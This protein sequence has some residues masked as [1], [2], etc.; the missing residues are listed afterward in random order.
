MPDLGLTTHAHRDFKF[1]ELE[2]GYKRT[3]STPYRVRFE[4]PSVFVELLF[5]GDRSFELGLLVGENCSPSC[6]YSIDEILWLRRAPDASTF[7]LIQ[8]TTRAAMGAWLRK[9]AKA[10]RSYG[11]DLIAGNKTSFSELAN[12]RHAYVRTYALESRLA[13]A[14]AE[15]GLAW[16]KKDYASVVKA[17]KPVRAA[18][19]AAEVGKLEFAESHCSE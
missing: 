15:A 5:D 7:S 17:L 12:Q 1:L 16:R 2:M 14:R 6:A 9:L 3:E 8:V 10:L 11:R 18:L 4:S 19:T 13:C